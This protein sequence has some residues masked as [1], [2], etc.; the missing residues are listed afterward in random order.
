MLQE[1]NILTK[2]VLNIYIEK[3]VV[4]EKCLRDI[5]IYFFSKKKRSM[6]HTYMHHIYPIRVNQYN[7]Y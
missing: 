1:Q 4:L 6:H 5:Y 3:I 2:R 7:K